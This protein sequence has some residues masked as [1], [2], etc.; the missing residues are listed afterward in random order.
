VGWSPW[1]NVLATTCGSTIRLWTES[2]R[3]LDELVDHKFPVTDIAWHPAERQFLCSAA[4]DGIRVWEIGNRLPNY[5]FKSECY[6]E[7]LSFNRSSILAFRGRNSIHVWGM[8]EGVVQKLP[9]QYDEVNSFDW[10][11]GGQWLAFCDNQNAFLWRFDDF[12]P[13]LRHT[14]PLNLSGHFGRINIV[15]FHP[16][17]Q[18]LACGDADGYVN[19][20]RTDADEKVAVG[21]SYSDSAVTTLAWNPL[22][23][24]LAIGYGNGQIQ[25]WSCEFAAQATVQEHAIV[26]T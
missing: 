16:Y 6:P 5:A 24:Q 8:R 9:G 15:R 7:Q 19:V 20:W 10:S 25:L 1:F 21:F 11:W 14:L 3:L 2:G 26:G 4:G 22:M 23:N 12:S 17:E 18:L 13:L